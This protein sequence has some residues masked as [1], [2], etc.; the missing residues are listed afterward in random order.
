MVW[1]LP[2]DEKNF[3]LERAYVDRLRNWQMASYEDYRKA[4]PTPVKEIVKLNTGVRAGKYD[5]KY[6]YSGEYQTLGCWGHA[7]DVNRKGAWFVLGGCEYFNDGP[8]KQDLTLAVDYNVIHFGR[9]HYNGSGIKISAGREWSKCFGPFLLY[10]NST[11]VDKSAGNALCV[12][13]R[14][15][16]RKEIA[17]WP[18]DWVKNPD[19]PNAAGRAAVSGRLVVKDAL[20]P[21]L[22]SAGAWVG[23]A[24]PEETAGNWQF[25]STGY[26]FWVHADAAG[27]FVIPAV[28]PGS[29]TLYAFTDGVVGE[30]S[31]TQVVVAAGAPKVLGDLVWQV[32]H[33]G[34][35]LAWEIG[36]AD[37]SA[38]EFHHGNDYFEPYLWQRLS[39]ELPNPM[40][41]HVG[42]SNPAADWNYV[43]CAYSKNGSTVPWKWRVHFDLPTVPRSGEATLTLAFAS[44]DFARIEVYVNDENR[45]L[46]SVSPSVSGGNALI[47][48]GI[49]A[50]YCYHTVA[51]PVARLRAG[52]NT[53]TL[54]PSRMGGYAGHVMYDYL[55]L[56]LP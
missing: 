24:A 5:C 39:A 17:A 41:Y 34:T 36:T 3:T 44:A 25:Q 8:V 14:E 49:H 26:Q 50:K 9:N 52:A 20:K 1:K 33:K 46:A 38:K 45:S 16:T 7:S 29:Y 43:Q 48:E 53:I 27:H 15:R 13:A 2:H 6:E 22:T 55:S 4:T 12:D 21:Q 47:R 11:T 31:K 35:S 37:R 23:L 32:P 51:I 42:R 18:Y 30:F 56:E 54:A 40:E 19:Y 28:R 10:C